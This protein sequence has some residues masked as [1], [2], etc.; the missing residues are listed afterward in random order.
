[1]ESCYLIIFEL[2][3]PLKSYRSFYDA[4]KAYGTW[5]KITKTTWAIVSFD[6]AADIR[7]YLSSFLINGDRI[8]VIKSGGKAAWINTIADN[9]WVKDN[10]RL[11]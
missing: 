5:G 11:I 8:L 2:N 6:N 4:M 10:L 3:R 9:N 1:M 7:D